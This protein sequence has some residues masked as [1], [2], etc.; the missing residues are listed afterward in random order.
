MFSKLIILYIIGYYIFESSVNGFPSN[1]KIELCSNYCSNDGICVVVDEYRQCYCL[2]EWTGEKCDDI[3]E[4]EIYND[5]QNTNGKSRAIERS[6]ECA[7]APPGMCLN[8]GLCKFDNGSF[9]CQCPHTYIGKRCQE[10][11]PCNGYCQNKGMCQLDVNS[12]P[13]CNCNGTGFAGLQCTRKETAAPT[14]PTPPPPTT[15]GAQCIGWGEMCN[16][17]TCVVINGQPKCQCPTG[18]SGDFCDQVQSGPP[19]SGATNP[20]GATNAPGQTPSPGVTC[21]QNPCRNNRP[22]Y[23]N[24]NTYFCYCGSAYSGVNCE[25]IAG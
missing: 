25:N 9:A 15:T 8:G 4:D 11:S 17:G 14:S 6:P 20:P 21:A 18:Y 16:P 19:S 12:D 24:G 2:P 10:S 22:C 13:K 3:K 7:V 23:N 1:E 5:I